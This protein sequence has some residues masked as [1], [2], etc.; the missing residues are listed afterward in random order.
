[1]ML[2]EVYGKNGN[3]L[4]AGSTEENYKNESG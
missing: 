1:M 2:W 4:F 3:G